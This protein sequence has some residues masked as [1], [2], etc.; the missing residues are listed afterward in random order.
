MEYEPPTPVFLST[1]KPVS[2]DEPSCHVRDTEL[3]ERAVPVSPTGAFGA[4]GVSGQLI[5]RTV[6][7]TTAASSTMPHHD[8]ALRI[9]ISAPHFV[10]ERKEQLDL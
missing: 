7:A 10:I 4:R 5:N 2:S 1:V 3:E 9:N 8:F 6:K